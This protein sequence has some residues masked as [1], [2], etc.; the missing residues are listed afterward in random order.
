MFA[1]NLSLLLC[2]FSLLFFILI[3]WVW[4]V[5]HEDLYHWGSILQLFFL[6]SL[7]V[8]KL[9][10]CIKSPTTRFVWSSSFYFCPSSGLSYLFN[11]L[12]FFFFGPRSTCI[13]KIQKKV[14]KVLKS[15][16]NYGYISFK[17]M[18]EYLILVKST[19]CVIF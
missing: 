15:K 17:C 6:L 12:I 11:S 8:L 1:E 16:N 18:R 4:R 3:F 7:R 9:A 13:K 14:Y 2:L 19:I 5:E 10:E